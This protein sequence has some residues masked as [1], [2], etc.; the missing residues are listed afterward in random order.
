[1]LLTTG[2][3]I[4]DTN[5]S[6]FKRRHP[7]KIYQHIRESL[8]PSQGWKRTW[9]Y[10]RHRIFRG[11]D[12]S[13]RITGGL[14]VGIGVSF[15]PFIGTHLA[16]AAFFAWLF[17]MNWVAA[18]VGTAWGNPWTFPFLFWISYRTG[19]WLCNL[20]SP[21]DFFTLPPDTDFGALLT[22][23]GAFF[24]Y[25]FDNPVKILLPLSVGS[26]VAALIAGILAYGVLY[27][28]VYRIRRAYHKRRLLKAYR[29]KR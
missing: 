20:F 9:H 7:R 5:M 15:T 1:M 11:G 4:T 16:Q 19:V 8:W 29:R 22:D 21:N 2:L 14:A 10:Y 28:P 3:L 17:R 23:P 6:L 18:L 13:H 27:A 12:S 25:L 24:G 26:Y